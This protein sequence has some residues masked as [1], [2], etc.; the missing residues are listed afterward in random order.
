MRQTLEVRKHEKFAHCNSIAYSWTFQAVGWRH[1]LPGGSSRPGLLVQSPEAA[2][3][4]SEGFTSM[5]DDLSGNLQKM[6]PAAD[7]W[8]RASLFNDQQRLNY[9]LTTK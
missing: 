7:D 2:S 4:L 3:M 6:Q 1:C 5:R 8:P 9:N